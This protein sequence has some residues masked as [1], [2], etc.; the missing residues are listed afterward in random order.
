M[1]D[2]PHRL[3][4]TFGAVATSV[5]L[6]A[7]TVAA[8]ADL[9]DDLFPFFLLQTAAVSLMLG[10]VAMAAAR[11]G[12]VH[13]GIWITTIA[14][15]V[16]AFECAS[17]TVG[18]WLLRDTPEVLAAYGASA[19][20]PNQVSL[21]VALAFWW[22]RTWV[23]SLGGFLTLGLLLFPDGRLP[24]TRWR[25]VAGVS[26]AALVVF[27]AANLVAGNP[28]SPI[29]WNTISPDTTTGTILTITFPIVGLC[30]LLSL[31]SLFVRHRRA[32]AEQRHQVRW[33]LFGAGAVAILMIAT[34]AFGAARYGLS[35][36]ETSRLV[37]LATLVAIPVLIA[38]YGVGVVRYRLYEIDVV[39][40]RSLVW[41][42]LAG[43]ITAVYVAIVVGLG[44]LIDDRSNLA[45]A[46]A[47][48]AAIAVIFEPV[49]QRI[50]RWANRLVYG[51]RAT[52]YE[53][54]AALNVPRETVEDL[55]ASGAE[56][57]AGGIGAEAVVIRGDDAV[58]SKWP[59]GSAG[60]TAWDLE[61]PM[62][63][64]GTRVGTVAV[65]KRQGDQLTAQDRRLVAEFADQTSLL[66]SNLLLNRRLE[67][68]LQEL[69]DSRRRLVTAQDEARRRLERD[70]HDGAQQELVALKVKLGLARQVARGEGA[71]E[72]EQLLSRISEEADEAVDTLRSLARGVYPPLLEAEGLE[73]AI[74]AHVRRLPIEVEF[75]VQDVGRHPREVESTV[76][77][78]LL[79]AINNALKH[80]GA[81]RV[82]VH[83]IE[84]DRLA[85]S[86]NDDGV[87]FR[88]EMGNGLTGMR[89]RL[90]T[91]GGTLSVNAM[92]PHGTRV[93]GT[94][95]L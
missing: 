22:E 58:V 67:G 31:A 57:I 51:S 10:L 28:S 80:S 16:M 86:V 17:M 19:L 77:F 33:M 84:R 47:A 59:H 79:E 81:E 89:D 15:V 9:V 41:G 36:P 12:T 95:P 14:G 69:S 61:L 87:G 48:T 46:V 65:A 7:V 11:R 37:N 32:D 27:T 60:R 42:V 83:V 56:A 4:F 8:L 54:L 30:I 3:L 39:I 91:V 6:T 55:V 13:I 64:D 34:F 78:C 92:S 5:S 93:E 24:S 52:P 35:A 63:H 71:S 68:R 26:L 1:M 44:S 21:E 29:P 66:L 53:V 18:A 88:G 74:A 73:A 72:V 90:D 20:A 25:P 43:F 82:E 94:V 2:R 62:Y 23:G 45:L 50:Q 75:D 40:N 38:A 49:R 76:Y 70:L 85:F